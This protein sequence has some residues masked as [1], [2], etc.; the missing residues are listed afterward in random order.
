MDEPT[1]PSANSPVSHTEQPPAPATGD[2]RKLILVL[3][4]MAERKRDD[5]LNLLVE[6]VSQFLDNSNIQSSMTKVGVGRR[7]FRISGLNGGQWIYDLRAIYWGDLIPSL[8]DFS[9]PQRA[10]HGL[11]LIRF[12]I[13]RILS[14]TVSEFRG[15][16]QLR[17][18]IVVGML[19]LLLWY[20]AS[21]VLFVQLCLGNVFGMDLINQILNK[22]D[23]VG[24]IVRSVLIGATALVA[25]KPFT[26][27]VDTGYAAK[28]YIQNIGAIRPK[29]RNR[30]RTSINIATRDL[31]GGTATIF[32]HSFG[33]VLTVELLAS[34]ETT[35]FK[36]RLVTA[37]SPLML[38]AAVSKVV[39]TKIDKVSGQKIVTIVEEFSEMIKKVDRH[40][41]IECWHDFCDS[42]DAFCM[43]VPLDKRTKLEP[44][45]IELGMSVADGAMGRAHDWYFK[46]YRVLAQV[47]QLPELESW[48][49]STKGDRRSSGAGQSA[50]RQ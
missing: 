15:L 11:L 49:G 42:K 19:A 44:E 32:A 7:E 50:D 43:P 25:W 22:N 31:G 35:H 21:L 41:G 45:E 6:G 4:G 33:T 38:L 28:A 17:W 8:T 46:D 24:A 3:S 10:Y 16:Q 39:N 34:L 18:W 37:G 20:G 9:L 36:F 26:M 12:W 2:V 1:T 40:Q 48:L 13:D 14:L 30:I 47:L 29:I 5:Y 23:T 27:G